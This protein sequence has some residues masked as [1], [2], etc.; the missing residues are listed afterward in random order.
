MAEQSV[1]GALMLDQTELASVAGLVTA[2]SFLLPEHQAM[3][4]AITEKANQ[5][6]PVDIVTLSS[7]L[8]IDL[9]YLGRIIRD[10]PS[11]ANVLAYAEIV[12][13]EAERRNLA[14]LLRQAQ[15]R[16]N[17]EDP[18][19]TLQALIHYA[20]SSTVRTQG[21]HFMF[22]H[23]AQ[24]KT[25]PPDW[26]ITD[27]FEAHALAEVFGA[28]ESGKS[29]LAIDWGLSVAAGI[30]WCGHSTQQGAVFYIAG[31][32]YHGLSRRFAAW[33]NHTGVAIANLP[34][35]TS[36]Q[37]AAFCNKSSAI[38]VERAIS[39]LAA[40]NEVSPKLV[41]VDT[42]ARNF[43]AGSENSTED[44]NAFIA[45]VDELRVRLGCAVLLVHHTGHSSPD[46]GR[47]S[48]ALKA[49]VDTEFCMSRRESGLWL[50]CTK[51]KDHAAPAPKGFSIVSVDLC[52]A[53]TGAV[54]ALMGGVMPEL[55][56]KPLPDKQAL[57]LE[58]LEKLLEEH[59]Q[60]FIEQCKN[61]DD[62]KVTEKLW[63]DRLGDLKSWEFRNIKDGLLK[64]DLISL[65]DGFVY[66]K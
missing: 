64:R 43:G 31:E 22:K 39:A 33:G 50:S 12:K 14:E 42:L 11:A 55:R 10:T 6:Q 4:R 23:I 7:S 65:L 54:L 53:G 17:Y 9:P 18:Q 36:E 61:Q 46:R 21:N 48:S 34:F 27:Y 13:A 28:P 49:A 25:A 30:N 35:F 5:G 66:L 58:A 44:M 62:A 38:A 51:S 20:E 1:L 24:I 59:Q 2:D 41:I 26:L 60:N 15:E 29:L 47:G 3:Y 45:H 57:A 16:V 37:A 8:E 63:R 32:G 40:K 56:E 52:E 19:E